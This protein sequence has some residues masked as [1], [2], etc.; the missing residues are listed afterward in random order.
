MPG[1]FFHQAPGDQTR[2]RGCQPHYITVV[3][4]CQTP[5]L[6]NIILML[7]NELCPDPPLRTFFH[8]AP[9][10]DQ[11]EWRLPHCHGPF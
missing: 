10:R 4:H 1:T 5:I 9:R 7:K 6:S 8:Q 2:R 11:T 3:H